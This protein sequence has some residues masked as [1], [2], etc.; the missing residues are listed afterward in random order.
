[1]VQAAK[2]SH[3]FEEWRKFS[4]CVKAK[5]RKTELHKQI[6]AGILILVYFLVLCVKLFVNTDVTIINLLALKFGI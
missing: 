4:R 1:V 6:H 3:T 2:L 5:L